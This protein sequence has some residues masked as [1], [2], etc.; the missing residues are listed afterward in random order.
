MP[1]GDGPHSTLV[2]GED[3]SRHRGDGF[4]IDPEVP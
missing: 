3:P 1:A 2:V 4:R